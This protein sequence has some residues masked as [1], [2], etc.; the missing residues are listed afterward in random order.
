MREVT[1]SIP[2]S[3]FSLFQRVMHKLGWKYTEVASVKDDSKEEVMASLD[4]AFAEFHQMQKTGRKGRR[5]EEL[6]DEL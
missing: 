4:R 6:I 1:I 5:A 3:D 2:N